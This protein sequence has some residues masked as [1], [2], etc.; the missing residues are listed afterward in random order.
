MCAGALNL[1]APPV[2]DRHGV[3][4]RCVSAGEGCTGALFLTEESSRGGR[5]RR[6]V[7]SPPESSSSV[8][9]TGES[10]ESEEEEDGAVSSQQGRWLDSFGS[11]LEDSLP[12]RIIKSLHRKSKSFGNLL[13]AS[14]NA[15]ELEKVESPL[16][17]RRRL[18]IA[19]KLRRRSLSVE[20]VTLAISDLID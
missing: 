9:V 10:S 19:N 13:E 2:D 1:R 20:E 8:G 5:L 11:S 18:L 4:G 3:S 15:K 14:N 7:K 16:N 17:K 12:E 6:C